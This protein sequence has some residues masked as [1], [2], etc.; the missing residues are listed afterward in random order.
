[1]EVAAGPLDQVMDLLNRQ[2][3]RVLWQCGGISPQESKRVIEIV[4]GRI[5]F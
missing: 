3:I 1:V 2:P 4:R 5:E